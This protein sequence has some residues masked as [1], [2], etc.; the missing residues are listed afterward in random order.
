MNEITTTQPQ[1]LVIGHKTM[2]TSLEIARMFGKRHD[3][4][5]R[6]IEEL[7]PQL[8]SAYCLLNFEEN[9]SRNHD[10]QRLAQI[11]YA[12]F[13]CKRQQPLYSTR[14]AAAE[15]AMNLLTKTASSP[16][17]TSADRYK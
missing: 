14:N 10:S 11:G 2:T 7:L 15:F 17:P 5:L 16:I 9:L 12:G 4:V 6:D 13:A 8:P 1:V 3:N